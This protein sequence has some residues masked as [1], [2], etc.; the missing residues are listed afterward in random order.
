LPPSLSVESPAP[1]AT[2]QREDGE[3]G[4]QKEDGDDAKGKKKRKSVSIPHDNSPQ[5]ENIA[6]NGDGSL[7]AVVFRN[8]LLG[9]WRTGIGSSGEVTLLA[10]RLAPSLLSPLDLPPSPPLS[11]HVLNVVLFSPSYRSLPRKPTAVAFDE[12]QSRGV[13]IVADR[14]SDV[15]AYLL[16]DLAR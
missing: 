15:R 13:V 10:Q 11:T 8:R 4:H 14:V 5:A 1:P 6:F 2:S 9:V 7:L 3:E 12:I 16:D